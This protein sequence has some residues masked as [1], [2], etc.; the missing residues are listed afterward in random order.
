MIR[1]ICAKCG[2][3]QENENGLCI[4]GH[5]DW[6]EIEG[7]GILPY[8]A[9]EFEKEVGLP[10]MIAFRV[11]N[12]DKEALDLLQTAHKKWEDKNTNAR[13]ED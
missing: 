12:G 4:H 8:Q 5:D 6:M 10:I 13:K 7:E 3:I 11:L 1:Y 9:E 2:G